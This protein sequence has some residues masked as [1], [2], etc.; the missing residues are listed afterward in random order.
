MEVCK[1]SPE[2]VNL[3][4]VTSKND[5]LVI[6]GLYF[7]LLLSKFQESLIRI[8]PCPPCRWHI[9]EDMSVLHKLRPIIE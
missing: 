1:Y 6:F 4:E 8:I 3:R 2:L 7:L 5:F 9:R